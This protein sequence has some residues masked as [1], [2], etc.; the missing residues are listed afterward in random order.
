MSAILAKFLIEINNNLR[1]INA[2]LN[3][4][5]DK[6]TWAGI[7]EI[8]RTG[9]ASRFFPIGSRIT[10]TETTFGTQQYDVVAHDYYRSAY[11]DNAHTMTLMRRDLIQPIQYGVPQALFVA[12]KDYA[13]GTYYFI[14]RNSV[15]KWAK[16]NYQF[17]LT[18][19]YPK[20]AQLVIDGT[21]TAGALT[22]LTVKTYADSYSDSPIESAPITAGSSGVLIGTEGV[23]LNN[24]YRVA[25]FSNN[26]K[27]SGVRQYL[28]SA[29]PDVA[30]T[31]I[32]VSEYDRQPSWNKDGGFAGYISDL[33][34]DLYNVIGKTTIHTDGGVIKDYIFLPSKEDIFDGGFPFFRNGDQS[35]RAKTTINASKAW[36]LR[37][38]KADDE[39]GCRV[40][41]ADTSGALA[42]YPANTDGL[43]AC[44]PC[45]NI[46]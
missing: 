46:M 33:P 28:N 39:T 26:Y 45:F 14:V 38:P 34:A 10:V 19:T 20:G 44:A 27:T 3:T 11:D 37:T 41:C 23:E 4:G 2:T 12:D 29:S 8:V 18:K 32:P 5:I 9:T 7:Q 35:D 1:D 15:D 22:T 40:Y 31:W 42:S 36:W 6:S 25:H 13:P 16:G 30:Q 17:T 21:S 24:I 43:C